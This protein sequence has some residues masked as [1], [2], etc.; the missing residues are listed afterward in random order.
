MPGFDEDSA[1]RIAQSV[2]YTERL[3]GVPST[4]P[5]ENYG[6]A[7]GGQICLVQTDATLPAGYNGAMGAPGQVVEKQPDGTINKLGAIWIKDQN[8]GTLSA[9]TIYQA[10]IGGTWTQD[11]TTSGIVKP[12]T[13]GLYLVQ[14][15][16]GGGIYEPFKVTDIT[17]AGILV[18]TLDTLKTGLAM[19]AVPTFAYLGPQSPAMFS[20]IRPTIYG[21]GIWPSSGRNLTIYK[22]DPFTFW[23]EARYY[24]ST[25]YGDIVTC[26]APGYIGN[27][28]P[29][30]FDANDPLRL[31]RRYQN[32]YGYCQVVLQA[33][34]NFTCGAS[35]NFGVISA[36]GFDTLY[37]GIGS[38]IG[39]GISGV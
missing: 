18:M 17:A 25:S 23:A 24:T 29:W 26:R 38:G 6:A 11:V 28:N 2:R 3:Q 7:I 32:N 10:R 13:L 15:S 9:N 22:I 21:S 1:K 14:K 30:N 20:I 27:A 12:M 36:N 33:F 16:G 8:G 39:S 31:V 37:S 19:P 4:D 35:N 5:N 34:P